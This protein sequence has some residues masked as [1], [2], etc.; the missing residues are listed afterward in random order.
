VGAV[1]GSL[2]DER[3][4][5][6]TTNEREAATGE[7]YPAQAYDFAVSES[8]A[9]RYLYV[10]P[11]VRLGLRFAKRFEVSAGL[12]ALVLVG[13]ANPQWQDE[14]PISPGSEYRVGQLRF[15]A[16]ALAGD[17]LFVMAPG[18]GLRMDL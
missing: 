2:R 18:L 16:Q 1:L 6:A 13:I 11:E 9:A 5:S 15:G 4:G 10:A 12:R 3:K 7:T 17:V 14:T 8:Q